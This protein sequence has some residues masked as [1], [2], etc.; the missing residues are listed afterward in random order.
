MIT[1]LTTLVYVFFYTMFLAHWENSMY[2]LPIKKKSIEAQV[3]MIDQLVY[4]VT[5]TYKSPRYNTTTTSSPS[6]SQKVTA[7]LYQLLFSLCGSGLE[8]G[9]ES[10]KGGA[11]VAHEGHV[12]VHVHIFVH[13]ESH[14]LCFLSVG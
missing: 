1:V 5:T 12:N 10:W 8:G 6:I 9:A 11:G 4:A 7:A 14:L 2:L 13:S 3:T